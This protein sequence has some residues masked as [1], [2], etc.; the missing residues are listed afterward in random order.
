MCV[1]GFELDCNEEVDGGKGQGG[2]VGELVKLKVRRTGWDYNLSVPPFASL[3]RFPSNSLS[4]SIYSFSLLSFRSHSCIV[5]VKEKTYIQQDVPT[6]IYTHN[7]NNSG[8]IYIGLVSYYASSISRVDYAVEDNGP[9]LALPIL[10][11]LPG[12]STDHNTLLRATLPGRII[13]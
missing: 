8:C 7:N 3:I 12:R 4:I 1:H 2:H 13:K 6:C 10:F 9:Q 11:F 5:A